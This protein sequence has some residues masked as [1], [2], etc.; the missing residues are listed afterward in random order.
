MNLFA[1]ISGING[2]VA[3]EDSIVCYMYKNL[4]QVEVHM[5]EPEIFWMGRIRES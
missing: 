2:I 3:G 1:L 4:M 5:Q